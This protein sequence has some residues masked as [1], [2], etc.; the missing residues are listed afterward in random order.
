LCKLEA[1]EVKEKNSLKVELL[2]ALVA[3]LLPLVDFFASN[4]SF[5][6]LPDIISDNTPVLFFIK[7]S[8]SSSGFYIVSLYPFY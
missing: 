8:K 2:A 4:F 3:Y 1:N 6:T 7:Y 5:S